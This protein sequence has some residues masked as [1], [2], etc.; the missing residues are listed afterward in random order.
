MTS[1]YKKAMEQVSLSPEA[2]DSIRESIRKN[3]R[4]NSMGSKDASVKTSVKNAMF[5]KPAARMA[6]M[7]AALCLPEQGAA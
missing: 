5:K 6:G 1:H 2:A 3:A 4:K 7:A